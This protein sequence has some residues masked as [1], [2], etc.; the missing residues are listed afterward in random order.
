M[1]I[2]FK[3]ILGA[4]CGGIVL[5]A[6]CSKKPAEGYLGVKFFYLSNPFVSPKGRLT[7]SA[8]LQVD[9]S[10]L[11]I[12]VT[13]TGI[14]GSS[15]AGKPTD[16]LTQEYDIP[17]FLGEVFPTDTTLAMVQAKLGTAKYKPFN[18]N[19]NGGRLELT[20]ATTFVDTGTYDFDIEVKNMK[21]S[22]QLKS[23][24]KIQI[25][26][27][28]PFQVVRQFASTSAVG[29]ETTLTTQGTFSVSV[30]RVDGPNKIV[31]RWVDK[32]G[33]TF[34]PK[35]GQVVPR[36]GIPPTNVVANQRYEFKLFDPYYPEERTD[37]ALVYQYPAGVPTFPLFTMNN[38]YICSYRI[39]AASNDL[40]VNI[41]PEFSVRLFPIN[42]VA[43]VTGTWIITNVVPFAAKK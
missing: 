26:P 5:F 8:P 31:I 7:T 9:N 13:L 19:A 34:N 42:G 17:V 4:L 10:T 40:N 32:N 22:K 11:P 36:L 23:I 3:S 21:A 24:A 12:T 16:K 25:T 43:T 41:N 33:A 29:N 18:V 37:T 27:A 6:A 30:V 15:V 38:G 28:V 35:T 14:R 20:P 2:I 39:P 1:K